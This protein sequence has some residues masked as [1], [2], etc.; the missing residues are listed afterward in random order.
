MASTRAPFRASLWRRSVE[1]VLFYT[2]LALFGSTC[3]LWTLFAAPLHRLLRGPAGTRIGQ[4]GIMT[5]FRGFLGAMEAMG[6]FRCDLRALD[7]LRDERGVV[8]VANHPS[9]LDA[10]L[11]ISRLP[12]VVCITKAALWDNLF[13]GGGIRLAS[14]IRNDAPVALVK[15]AVKQLADGHQL[16]VFPEGTRTVHPPVDPFLPGFVLM[17]RAAGVPIQTVFIESNSRYLGKGWP[18]FRKPSFPL[19]YRARLGRRWDASGDVRAVAAAI[20]AYYRADSA[21]S[22]PPVACS[23]SMSADGLSAASPPA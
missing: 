16:L 20:E 14:Y 22:P 3:L 7:T 8:I 11:V 4:R 21:A 2:G 5:G 6:L 13:L 15:Q 9:L 18:L 17:A 12:R 23:G 10:V 1:Y 19:R